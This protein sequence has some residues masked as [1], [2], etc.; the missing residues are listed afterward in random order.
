MS[1]F[2]IGENDIFQATYCKIT[3]K[4]KYDCSR[5]LPWWRGQNHASR[6]YTLSQMLWAE[7]YNFGNMMVPLSSAN[8]RIA[9]NHARTDFPNRTFP[10]PKNFS[11][12]FPFPYSTENTI[13]LLCFYFV[14]MLFVNTLITLFFESVRYEK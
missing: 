2:S 12:N 3:L 6:F 5:L 9:C 13:T 14:L 1:V 4:F 8:R 7:M 10:S 11:S